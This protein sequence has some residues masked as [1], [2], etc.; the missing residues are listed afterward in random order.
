[1]GIW[2]NYNDLTVLRHRNDGKPDHPQ[3]SWIQVPSGDLS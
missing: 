2:I 3:M 1:M